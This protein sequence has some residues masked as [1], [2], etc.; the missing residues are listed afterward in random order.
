MT[1][2][3][4]LA[5]PIA[6]ERG[7]KAVEDVLIEYRDARISQIRGNGC[8]VCEAD[9]RPSHIIRLGVDDALRIALTAI[10]G[11]AQ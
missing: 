6:L 8:V 10:V 3:E 11:G 9:G 5:D 2:E 4:L 1:V 7:R